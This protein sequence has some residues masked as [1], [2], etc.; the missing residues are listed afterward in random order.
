MRI[1]LLISVRIGLISENWLDPWVVV[2]A[3]GSYVRNFHGGHVA[4]GS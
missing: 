2:V 4:D 1:D 3:H